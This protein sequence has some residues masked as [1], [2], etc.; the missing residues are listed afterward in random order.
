[1]K[2]LTKPLYF[3]AIILI[4]ASGLVL[5]ALISIIFS[6]SAPNQSK[7]DIAKFDIKDHE[8]LYV[9]IPT[10]KS[11]LVYVIDVDPSIIK[12]LRYATTD[13]FT[14][15]KIYPFSACLLQKNTAKKLKE[16]N[17][18]FKT[19][20]YTIKIWDAYRPYDVQ[21]YL[22]SFVSDSRFIANPNAAGSRHNR[23]AAVDITLV[24]NNNNNLIMPTGFDAFTEKAYR[25]APM[26]DEARKN[27]DL[28]TSIM[29][30]HGFNTIETEWWHYDDTDAD[31][32]PIL[33]ITFEELENLR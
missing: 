27:V 5:G 14:H 21:K 31:S 12:E 25:N 30:K 15:T 32:Y 28:L 4:I 2:R 18:E 9:K 13:N 33:N 17:A 20:G 7:L 8:S 16:A 10:S 11:G 26:S 23:G 3:I 29:K 24:D 1:M 22:W 19:L 6:N